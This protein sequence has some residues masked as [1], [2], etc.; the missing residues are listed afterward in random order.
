MEK[1]YETIRVGGRTHVI[2][3]S[4]PRGFYQ[5]S[6]KNPIG[7]IPEANYMNTCMALCGVLKKGE[8]LA[9]WKKRKKKRLA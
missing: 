5:D 2:T 4:E 8:S 1:H 3:K 6:N 7:E 9:S